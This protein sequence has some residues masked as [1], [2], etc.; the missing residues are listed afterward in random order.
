M[1][2]GELGDDQHQ[3]MSQ[4]NVRRGVSNKVGGRRY[5]FVMLVSRLADDYVSLMFY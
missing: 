3:N 2:V 4:R 5:Q 1:T